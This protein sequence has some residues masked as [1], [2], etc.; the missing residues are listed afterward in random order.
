MTMTQKSALQNLLMVGFLFLIFSCFFG[1]SLQAQ[2]K[3]DEMKLMRII[4]SEGHSAQKATLYSA[5]I[6]GWGQAYN[7]K[8]WKIPI[9]WAGLGGVGYFIY[10]NNSGYN[11]YKDYY[12][13]LFDNPDSTITS[14]QNGKPVSW[15]HGDLGTIMD[16]ISYI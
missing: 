3:I 6:P 12:I 4:K 8:Y 11:Q 5:V 1:S 15:T 16:N 13:F 14:I 10:S 9:V 7:R 2:K